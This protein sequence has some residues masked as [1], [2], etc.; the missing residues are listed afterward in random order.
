MSPAENEKGEGRLVVL[1]KENSCLALRRQGV[2]ERKDTEGE[3]FGLRN[4]V[5]VGFWGGPGLEIE[6]K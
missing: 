3:E 2:K 5:R 4:V 6:G 1:S